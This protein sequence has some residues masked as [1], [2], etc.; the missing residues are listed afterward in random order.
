MRNF[1]SSLVTAIAIV[2]SVPTT[3]ILVT[4][5]SLPGDRL[6][7]V[8]TAFEDGA[9]FLTV[10]TPIGSALSIDFTQRRFTEANRLL[11]KEGST[12]GYS[13]VVNEVIQSKVIIVNNNDY[14][15]G[16]E[17]VKKIEEYQT[18][19]EEKKKAIQIEPSSVLPSATP[20]TRRVI[21]TPSPLS[22]VQTTTPSPT[23]TSAPTTTQMPVTQTES[24][25]D[26]IDNLDRTQRELEDIKEQINHQLPSQ[27][28]ERAVEVHEASP[29][30]RGR[31]NND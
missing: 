25:E 29:Q 3:L 20:A 4:W 21:P 27:A 30:E 14:N 15:K 23:P 13:Y 5:N 2:L 31:G 1:F 8:K 19:I 18:A 11:A 17:L 12:V 16:Q 6:Y 10:H 7:P 28:S 24:P 22:S 9:L 26:V